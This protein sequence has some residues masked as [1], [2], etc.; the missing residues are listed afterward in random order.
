LHAVCSSG[1]VC[2]PA[3]P[4]P[5][6]GAPVHACFPL[7]TTHVVCGIAALNRDA[8]CT[9]GIVDCA[10]RWWDEL[11]AFNPAIARLRNGSL[12]MLVRVSNMNMCQV[13]R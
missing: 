8:L 4:S 10:Q 7:R 11:A 1:A 2:E 13:A 5:A 9:R 3:Q 6:T 12:F